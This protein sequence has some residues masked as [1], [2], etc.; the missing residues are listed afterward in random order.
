MRRSILFPLISLALLVVAS[1]G[2]RAPEC[3]QMLECCEAVEDLDGVGG[4]CGELAADT[5]DPMTCRNIV[6]TVRY[7][8]ED[9][10]Q[11]LPDVCVQ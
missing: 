4:A 3:K 7:M 2:C 10:D 6:R 5:R 11:P 8:L 1:F 9:N